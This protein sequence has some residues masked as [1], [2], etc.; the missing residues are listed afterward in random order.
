MA[1]VVLLAKKNNNDTVILNYFT[2]IVDRFGAGIY[3]EKQ[4]KYRRAFFCIFLHKTGTAK[5][6]T[7]PN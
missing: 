2:Q 7:I 1:L 4:W 5:Q 3:F 6:I